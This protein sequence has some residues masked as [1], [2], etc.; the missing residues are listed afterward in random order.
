MEEEGDMGAPISW[1]CLCRSARALTKP[2]AN[3]SCSFVA[4]FR[5][6]KGLAEALGAGLV[7]TSPWLDWIIRCSRSGD[8]SFRR[9]MSG[10]DIMPRPPG[11]LSLRLEACPAKLCGML[12]F[13]LIIL[14]PWYRS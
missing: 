4:W 1:F 14:W 8:D 7:V 13:L 9:F 6:M 10:E 12:F 3:P 2:S 5:Y 11:P